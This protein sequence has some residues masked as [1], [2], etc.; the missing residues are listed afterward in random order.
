MIEK[1]KKQRVV[2]IDLNKNTSKKPKPVVAPTKNTNDS[3]PKKVVEK[4]KP[5]LKILNREAFCA[6]LDERCEFIVQR[7]KE[8]RQGSMAWLVTKTA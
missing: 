8:A 2:V 5:E 3:Q 1:A 4:T 6:F 7:I